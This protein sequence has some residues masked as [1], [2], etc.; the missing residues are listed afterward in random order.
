MTD[1]KSRL[2]LD[3]DRILG[4]SLIELGHPKRHIA[5]VSG[6]SPAAVSRWADLEFR[7][8]ANFSPEF[9][10]TVQESAGRI[11]QGADYRTER[12]MLFDRAKTQEAVGREMYVDPEKVRI[13][14]ERMYA[15]GIAGLWKARLNGGAD[16]FVYR[17]RVKGRGD[18]YMGEFF[19]FPKETL[20]KCLR[21]SPVAERPFLSIAYLGEGHRMYFCD[22]NG[23]HTPPIHFVAEVKKDMLPLLVIGPVKV[24]DFCRDF[25]RRRGYDSRKDLATQIEQTALDE[26]KARYCGNI[27]LPA[28]SSNHAHVPH[29]IE[30][31]DRVSG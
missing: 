1:S 7:P 15:M 23:V 5:K 9:I 25:F 16:I 27:S 30:S 18:K 22:E 14:C 19:M 31:D 24:Y 2:L 12:D 26:M 11:R 13:R 28:Y 21:E 20:P 6:R 8:D 3:V 10:A 4:Y 29:R 17:D